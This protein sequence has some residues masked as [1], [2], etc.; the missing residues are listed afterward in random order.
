[1]Q[2]TEKDMGQRKSGGLERRESRSDN[3]ASRIV[4]SLRGSLEVSTVFTS[5]LNPGLSWKSHSQSLF[6]RL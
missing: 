5:R 4:L 2:Y 6:S 3:V 1:M